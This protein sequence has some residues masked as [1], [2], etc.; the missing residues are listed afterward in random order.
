MCVVYSSVLGMSSLGEI[1]Y[2]GYGFLETLE[3]VVNQAVL[4]KVVLSQ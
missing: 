4:L 2:F 1:K 3:V